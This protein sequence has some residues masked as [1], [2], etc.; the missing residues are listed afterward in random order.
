MAHRKAVRTLRMKV[1]QSGNFPVVN[2]R[3]VE[4]YGYGWDGVEEQMGWGL[5]LGLV[6]LRTIPVID[7]GT[8]H[9]RKVEN[10]PQGI[11]GFFFLFT[12][13]S[14]ILETITQQAHT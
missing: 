2:A 6:G 8:S 10:T 11:E 14:P 5:G 13:Y 1:A 12:P 9:F 3:S 4:V 7:R